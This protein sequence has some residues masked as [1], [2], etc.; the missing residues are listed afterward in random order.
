MIAIIVG[1]AIVIGATAWTV[2]ETIP[3][4]S[5]PDEYYESI[6]TG[7]TSV[8][9]VVYP[10]DPQISGSLQINKDKYLLGENIY[11]IM[12]HQ[13]IM[14]IGKLVVYTPN[15]EPYFI[16]DFDAQ[17][18]PSWK[19]YFSPDISLSK[20]M[21]SYDKIVGE[22]TIAM[23]YKGDMNDIMY[24]PIKFTLLDVVLPNEEYKFFHMPVDDE[25]RDVK[26]LAKNVCLM[27]ESIDIKP[28]IEERLKEQTP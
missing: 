8:S 28:L 26:G 20:G 22:W 24:E 16:Y 23:G 9:R 6:M 18:K 4:V 21:C 7:E 11:L 15:G 3:K 19:T 14:E 1:S 25:G 27:D 5:T 12:N 10:D 2:N 13:S 17:V